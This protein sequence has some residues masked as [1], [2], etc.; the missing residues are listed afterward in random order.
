M[1]WRL[2]RRVSDGVITTA[3]T[4][5]AS[6]PRDTRSVHSFVRLIDWRAAR[7]AA[8]SCCCPAK[9]IVIAIL[10]PAGTRKSPADLLLCA[11]H[12]RRSR[13]A[14]MAALAVV[15]DINGIPLGVGDWPEIWV[16]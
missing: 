8:R 4:T 13:A 15:T 16:V 9:P 11:H 10:P 7:K 14:L 3:I 5:S 2:R 12:F 6:D 1:T